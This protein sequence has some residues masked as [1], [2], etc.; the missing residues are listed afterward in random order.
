MK[1]F[2]KTLNT[3]SRLKVWG[4]AVKN[5]KFKYGRELTLLEKKLTRL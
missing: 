1:H 5:F 4:V 3:L 2:I